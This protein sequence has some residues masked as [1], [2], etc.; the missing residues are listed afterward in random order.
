MWEY[1][2]NGRAPQSDNKLL[3]STSTM[4]FSTWDAWAFADVYLMQPFPVVYGAPAPT[5]WNSERLLKVMQGKKNV[6]TLVHEEAGHMDLYD[7]ERF[8]D[9]TVREIHKLFGSV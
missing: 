9:P 7:V 6:R 3:V 5:K 2:T 8:V 1:Y 4:A